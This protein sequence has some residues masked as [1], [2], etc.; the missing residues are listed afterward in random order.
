MHIK[1][2]VLDD[3]KSFGRTTRIPFYEDF[4]VVTGPN[5]SGKSNIIDGVLFALGLARTRGIR[6]EKL[7]D[8]IY[9]PGHDGEEAGNAPRE[10]SVEVIL[11]NADGTLDRSQV[12]NAAGSDDVGDTEEIRIRRRVKETDENYYSYYYL[13]DRSVNLSDIRDLLAQAGV[14]PEGYNVVMQGDVTEIINMTPGQ[15]REVL[16]EIAGVAEFDAKKE[17]AFEELE[18]VEERIDE[19]DLRIGEKEDRLDRLADERETALEY[20]G[21]REEKETY[22]GYLRAAELEAKRDDLAETRAEIDDGEER[23]TDLREELD[24]RQARVDELE[25]ELDDLNREIE[26][27]GEDEQ[28]AIKA[29][30]EEIKG[31][32]SRLEGKIENQE[33]RADEAETERREAF[34]AIDRKN[35]E[36]DGL[37]SDIRETKVEKA[38]LKSSLTSKRTELAE[39]Q[40]EIDDADTEFD[41]LK[42]DLAEQKE[43][44]ERLRSERN[45]LQ[46]EKDRLLDEA[47]RRSNE[48]SEV[49]EELTETEES[50]P[51]LKRR[52]SDLHSELDTA[53]KNESR[54]R[55]VI[56]ELSEE[57]SATESKLE[58]VEEE[59][60]ERQQEYSQLEARADSSG[61]ASWPRSVTTV[62]N[63][64]F[65]GVHGPVGELASVDSEYATACE[66]AA[67]GRLANVVVDDDGVGSDCIDYLKRRNAGRA[68]FLPLT[69]MDRRGL[70]SAPSDPGVVGFARNLVEYDDEYEGVFSYVLGSTL[71]VEDMDTARAH[72]GDFR[73]V[74]LDGDL[75]ERSGA[76]TGGSGGGSRYAFSKS[77]K[78]KLER[79]AEEIHSLEDDRQALKSE[80]EE[81]EADLED[82]RSRASDAAEKVRDIEADLERAE[83]AVEEA[84]ASVDEYE[85]RI[86]ELEAERESVDAE[87]TDLDER[88]D[89]RDESIAETEATVEEL[90]AELADSEIPELSERADEVRSEIADLEDRM[91]DLDG[92]L[93]QLQLEKQYAEDAVDDLHETVEEAQAKKADAEERVAEFET[94]IEE[95]EAGLE[96]KH[97]AIA[98]LEE[99]LADLKEERE[100]VKADLRE[101]ES[102]RDDQREAVE[103]VASEVES[104]RETAERLEWEVEELE[105]RVGSYDPDEIPD[106]DTVEAEI[107][108]LEGEMEALEPVNM[109][110]IDEYDEV[111]SEL[112]DL[113]ERRGVL[114]DER[115]AIEERIERFEAQKKGTFMD[116]YESIDGHFRDIF[117]RL[118]AGSGELV[119]EDPDDPFEGGLTMKAQ[120]ADKPV[121]RLD[122]MSGGEKSL[123]ALAF[124]FA[125]Q[126]HNPAPFYALDEIDA[127][128]DAV[129]AERVGEMVDEL[130]G[131]AQFVVVSHRSALLE[132]SERAIGVTM[133]EDN[134]SAVTGIQL[135]EGDPA[136]PEASADD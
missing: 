3:F 104:L 40:A 22:E 38:N 51:D 9:N 111:E 13:N 125:I 71:V 109:L 68:T 86:E 11:D 50:I 7:T 66:T 59:I 31:E 94:A 110:A 108:R 53:E 96:E 81:I 123:T 52:V 63:A 132:R 19:A 101:V 46:R 34:V 35:E 5:G 134:V 56:E 33:E 4:T 118:S 26:R 115:D 42:A 8:L 39:I 41:E 102:A 128:L 113:E 57:R 29:E 58:A 133:Q 24:D 14:T 77:G 84:E 78:G 15:R 48:I 36:I 85:A 82:A 91:D 129:N 114:A 27:K 99:E 136:E 80:I 28:L 45:D 21:L 60:R 16:D 32:V 83:E 100:S 121:Q 55:G 124:I 117:E 106:H 89:E 64:D 6:A 93:N 97:E 65:S 127:F 44:V 119:L 107:E 54:V 47:R 90:E 10:A 79:V 131:E 67:G 120:P 73:M 69:E 72:M 30:I 23:L 75:V 92:D 43:R 105:E 17:D 130:A 70:P 25:S 116:A 126:R 61:D 2:L 98:D 74:T 18:T 49:E 20:Q 37:E 95:K 62:T 76:M 103:R 135:G 88:I 122:A 87:M 112:S 1:E 12:V